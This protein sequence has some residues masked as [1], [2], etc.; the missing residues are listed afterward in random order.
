MRALETWKN[1]AEASIG[2]A[3]RPRKRNAAGNRHSITSTCV[4]SARV[5]RGKRL[6]SRKAVGS[7]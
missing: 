1:A 7:P 4:L 6:K 3:R 2:G 5:M